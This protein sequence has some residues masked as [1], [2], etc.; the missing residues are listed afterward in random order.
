M[1]L[2]L[3]NSKTPSLLLLVTCCLVA[4]LVASYLQG[5]TYPT[6]VAPT[7]KSCAVKSAIDFT[8]FDGQV[9]PL[10]AQMTLAEKVGQM[11]QAELMFVK[12]LNEIAELGIG[13]ILS[14][15]N[16]DPQEGNSVEAWTNVYDRCQKAAMK[17]R[18]GI[19][20]LYGIDAIHGHNNV[21]GATIF[22]HNI[23]LGCSGNPKLV[24]RISQITAL[25]VR[26]TGI[27]WS[28]APCVTV[29]RD[30]RWGRTYEGFSEQPLLV[31][32][33]GA[34]SIRGLQGTDLS[35]RLRVLGCAKHFAGDG[36]TTAEQGPSPFGDLDPGIRTRL[37]RGDTRCDEETFRAIHLKPYRDAIEAGVGSVMP[38]YSSW[39]GVK[40]TGNKWLLT[41][42]LKKEL[43]FKGFVIT[44][45]NAIDEVHKDYKQAIKICVNAGIDMAMVP[46]KHAE[47]HRL[48]VELVNEGAVPMARINDA[49]TRIIRVKAAMGLLDQNRSQLADRAL[50]AKV[51]SK[52]HQQIARQAVRESLVLLK[53]ENKVLPLSSEIRRL[54]LCGSGAD[55]IG[56]QCGG[57][58]INWQGSEGEVT[59][60]G[61]TIEQALKKAIKPEQEVICSKDDQTA[62][63][64]DVAV[65]VVSETPYAE[66]LGDADLPAISEDD[67][68]L[69]EE[70]KQAGKPIVLVILSGRPIDLGDALDSADSV[71]AA[72]LPGTRGEG[73]AD[74]LLGDYAPTGKLSFS[75]PTSASWNQPV[76]V[77]E[78]GVSPL[79]NFGHGL[80]YAK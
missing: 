69:L 56:R 32:S 61:T 12:D 25:E 55:D 16:S 71:V 35:S 36:G 67:R 30:D 77:G 15:G 2:S 46:D 74:V 47:Y 48:L 10:L 65:L 43:G 17:S 42:V 66:G 80:S 44:D 78:E 37:D 5:E 28:F 39:N 26:A 75:W 54:Y 38:S 27:Q 49:V 79:F 1:L 31:A 8:K 21:D 11:T 64:A 60:G 19:P 4:V 13:S 9:E 14:G 18:L 68:K 52:E 53:N 59:T 70:I 7:Q 50:H 34:S 3:I 33:F 57:W 63:D 24:E 51:A 58:T 72:W 41:E 23:G 45:Y 6:S 73:V 22:P 76:N 29:P 20:I 40:C 62:A